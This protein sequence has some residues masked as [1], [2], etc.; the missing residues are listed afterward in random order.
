MLRRTYY[1]NFQPICTYSHHFFLRPPYG[2]FNKGNNFADDSTQHF[3]CDGSLHSFID[4][5]VFL[6]FHVKYSKL[7]AGDFSHNLCKF[8]RYIWQ[9]LS[10]FRKNIIQSLYIVCNG[11]IKL[12]ITATFCLELSTYQ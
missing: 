3:V 7:V 5:I 12:H 10:S 8:K 9:M 2:A 6:I 1:Q 4:Q 11:I